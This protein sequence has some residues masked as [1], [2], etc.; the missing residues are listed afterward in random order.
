MI[1]ACEQWSGRHSQN[2]V[3]HLRGTFVATE[4]RPSATDSYLTDMMQALVYT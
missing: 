3:K 2:W 1:L 4:S